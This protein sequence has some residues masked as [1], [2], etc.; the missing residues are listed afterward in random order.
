MAEHRGVDG[1]GGEGA[2]VVDLVGA[3]GA[4]GVDEAGEGDVEGAGGEGFRGGH[5]VSPSL[6]EVLV[7]EN[8]GYY[9]VMRPAR[10]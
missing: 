6:G 8:D 5:A 3:D 9:C 10:K 7:Y 4:V 1:G 2:V